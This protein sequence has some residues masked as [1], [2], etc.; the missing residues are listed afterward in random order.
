MSDSVKVKCKYCDRDTVF[1][2]DAVLSEIKRLSNY[3]YEIL[4][5]QYCR[6]KFS[7]ENFEIAV[8]K[9][10]SP[11]KF[12]PETPI[13]PSEDTMT[14]DEREKAKEEFRKEHEILLEKERSIIEETKKMQEGK[15]FD[16]KIVGN[17]EMD[18]G[19]PGDKRC[20]VILK[21]EAELYGYSFKIID[22]IATFIWDIF[23]NIYFGIE[24]IAKYIWEILKKINWCIV[25]SVARIAYF[26]SY[27]GLILYGIIATFIL[28]EAIF[29]DNY[30]ESLKAFGNPPP[31]I[32]W[33]VT[34]ILLFAMPLVIQ[35]G[36]A[37]GTPTSRW[38]RVIR[39]RMDEI[40]T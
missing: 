17:I 33:T 36:W 27:I 16:P 24:K 38:A 12:E 8:G 1:S 2:T 37:I 40:I 31:A 30:I 22:F 32:L 19:T 7:K 5:C 39:K 14:D 10:P 18:K 29:N 15:P 4:T 11:I 6:R 20:V 25:C 28:H 3:N 34:I 35:I 13:P 23:R 26:I 9:R 21:K